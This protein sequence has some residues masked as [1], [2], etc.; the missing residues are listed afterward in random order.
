MRIFLQNIYHSLAGNGRVSDRMKESYKFSRIHIR[1]I[2]MVGVVTHPLFYI[3][4]DQIGDPVYD[5]LTLRMVGA[6]LCLPG[7]FY[8]KFDKNNAQRLLMYIWYVAVAFNLP[9]FFAFGLLQF[10]NAPLEH[11]DLSFP[12]SIQY[13]ISLM[14]L[15]LLVVDGIVIALL[16]FTGTFLAC[17]LFWLTAET[18]RFDQINTIII[19]FLPSYI[20]ILVTGSI[21]NRN[22][23]IIQ[24]E[25]LAAMANIGSN[26]AHELRTPLLGI[27]ATAQGLQNYLPALLDAYQLARDNNLPVQNIRKGQ[28][29][30]LKNGLRRIDAETT[31][32]NT[33]IDMLL[34]NSS[35]QPLQG[36]SLERISAHQS[37]S[38]AI[39]RFPFNGEQQRKLV[40]VTYEQDFSIYAAPLL[41]VHVFFNLLKNSLYYIEKSGKG[42][43]F[44]TFRKGEYTNEIMVEDTGTGILTSDLGQV[45]DRFFT[46]TEIGKGSGIGLSFCKMVM[47]GLSGDIKCDSLTGKYTRFYLQFPKVTHV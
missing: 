20:F 16:Y 43:I 8:D 33:I 31:H 37:V 5:S 26:I 30:S 6:G 7:L 10:A 17:I 3:Y 45:F 40:H 15:L 18:I 25:K 19:P 11:L 38:D 1:K 12:W 42:E 21:F 29:E 39:E 47:H 2:A 27:K 28:L 36:A 34:V 32:S 44:F 14:L 13:A 9:F 24:Q 23:E 35:N 41:L 22:R 46:T 4:W